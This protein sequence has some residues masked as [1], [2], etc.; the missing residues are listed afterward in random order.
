MATKKLPNNQQLSKGFEKYV[1]QSTPKAGFVDTLKLINKFRKEAKAQGVSGWIITFV[2]PYI[3]KYLAE[4]G[5]EIIQELIDWVKS[6][7]NLE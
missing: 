1:E 2:L 3:E 6:Q 4:H 5:A 7:F